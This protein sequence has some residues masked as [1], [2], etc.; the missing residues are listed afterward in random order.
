MPSKCEVRNL[1][2][3][4]DH[5][6]ESI[7]KNMHKLVMPELVGPKEEYFVSIGWAFWGLLKIGRAHV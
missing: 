5:C 6:S 4:V 7:C 1:G 3:R 2:D